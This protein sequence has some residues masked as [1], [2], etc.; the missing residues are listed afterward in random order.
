M[1]FF[2]V[3]N[4]RYS[5]RSFSSQEVEEEK[6][7][8]ALEAAR[9]APSWQN[10]QPWRFIVVRNKEKIARIARLRLLR[11]NINIFLKEAP[12]II[13]LCGNPKDSGT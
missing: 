6:L 8:Q 11:L 10:R 3:I 1:D 9:L 5:C 4:R 13:I 12:V 7:F 2:E